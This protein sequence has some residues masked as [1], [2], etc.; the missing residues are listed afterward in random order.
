MSFNLC[1]NSNIFVSLITNILLTKNICKDIINLIINKFLGY[2]TF[3][4]IIELSISELD[5]EQSIMS[6]MIIFLKEFKHSC[7]TK[8]L[9]KKKM[10][11][12]SI[13]DT[14]DNTKIYTKSRYPKIHECI[15][16]L[17]DFDISIFNNDRDQYTNKKLDDLLK[18]LYITKYKFK[19]NSKFC[20][21]LHYILTT[22]FNKNGI[23]TPPKFVLWDLMVGLITELLNKYSVCYVDTYVNTR[24]EN[25]CYITS[26]IYKLSPKDNE[27]LTFN[28]SNMYSYN[29]FKKFINV[30]KNLQKELYI[31][32]I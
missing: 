15:I 2:N 16:F 5:I 18:Y 9:K 12:V 23:I 3:L 6:D 28:T 11:I 30:H 13:F 26:R 27:L 4:S 29:M 14:I 22:T 31:N 24:M 8:C 21:D 10:D 17:K 25:Y 7:N 32:I 19:Q 1:K 20:G